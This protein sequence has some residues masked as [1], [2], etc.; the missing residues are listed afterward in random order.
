MFD[1]DDQSFMTPYTTKDFDNFRANWA[2]QGRDSTGNLLEHQTNCLCLGCTPV[3]NQYA[4]TERL[5]G[6]QAADDFRRMQDGE[7]WWSIVADDMIKIED[8][9]A[10][11][12]S[13]N[14]EAREAR[15]LAAVA[16]YERKAKAERVAIAAGASQTR[17]GPVEIRKIAEP[18]KFLYSC[19]GTPARPTTIHVSSECW[20]HDKGVCMRAHPAMPARAA[21]TAIDEN[22][23]SYIVSPAMAARPADPL[24]CPQWQSNRTFRA[25]VV[26]NRF[27]TAARG[28]PAPPQRR[29]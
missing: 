2:H 27:A 25:P 22:G 9:Q 8:R 7:S 28:A 6:F 29:W 14:R 4:S 16:A 21:V 13:R 20:S 3:V 11:E 5:F 15:E 12:Y 19:Q 24:W 26:E 10:A 18:C 17:R 23:K 1:H